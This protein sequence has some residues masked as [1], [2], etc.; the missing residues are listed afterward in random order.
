MQIPDALQALADDLGLSP[1][2]LLEAVAARDDLVLRIEQAL[3]PERLTRDR[4]L[5]PEEPRSEIA[6]RVW[7][8]AGRL[9]ARY[10]EYSDAFRAAMHRQNMTWIR[11]RGQWERRLAPR[12]GRLRDRLVELACE[13]LAAGF[14]CE[15]PHAGLRED[16]LAERYE[17]EH[18]RWI[19]RRTQGKYE[20]HFA[21]IWDRD[22][23][24][25][26]DEAKALPGSRW[27]KP[28]AGIAAVVVPA[29]AYE[30]VL[31]FAERFGFRLSDA[32]KDL[33][34]AARAA[35]AAELVATPSQPE[36]AD[37]ETHEPDLDPASVSPEI[38][39]ALKDEPL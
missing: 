35:E 29:E 19:L 39:P 38:D 12:M 30:A 14:V 6:A 7:C 21:L 10:P 28:S 24:D 31:D 8:E 13:V 34:E 27:D 22:R 16:V 36:K 15:L 37:P 17:K 11:S 1:E 9:C 25:F 2:A 33:V 5:R 4:R 20:G 26:Y 3:R 18:T 32:A 23:D